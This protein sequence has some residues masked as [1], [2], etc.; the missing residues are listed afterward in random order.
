MTTDDFGPFSEPP[1]IVHTSGPRMSHGIG[2]FADA[3]AKAQMEMGG[4]AKDATNPHFRNRYPTLASVVEACRP[5]AKYGIAQLQPARTDGARVTITTLFVHKSGEWI[6]EDLTLTAG[7]NTPQAVGSALTY[8]RR[9]ALAAMAGIAPTDDTD[10]DGEAAEGRGS[11]PPMRQPLPTLAPK[12][13]QKP[14]PPPGFTVWWDD[15]QALADE[16][17]A[18]LEAAWTKS[19]KDLRKHLTEHYLPQ[20]QAVKDKAKAVAP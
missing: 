11:A 7:A 4:A 9:Y 18:A 1:P 5:L 13:V 16:G 20:W 15:L 10:D 17:K 2:Q 14:V 3:L 8:G 19:P 12:S 6:A